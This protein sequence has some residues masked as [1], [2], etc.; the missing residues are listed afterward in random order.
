MP[1]KSRIFLGLKVLKF[2]SKDR[3]NYISYNQNT[4]SNVE[5]LKLNVINNRFYQVNQLYDNQ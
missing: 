4:G 2:Y 1:W 3:L 5:H